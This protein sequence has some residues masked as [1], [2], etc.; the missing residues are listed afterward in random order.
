MIAGGMACPDSTK[1]ALAAVDSQGSLP[2]TAVSAYL[3]DNAA[4]L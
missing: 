4:E 2:K 1:S 3:D